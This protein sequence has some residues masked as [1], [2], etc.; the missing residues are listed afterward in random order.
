MSAVNPIRLILVRHAEV[1]ARYQKIFGGKIDMNLS[2]R[3]SE[4]A[5]M[6]ANFL[7]NKPMDA[8][9]A[10]PMKRVQ[11]T[12]AP[13]LKNHGAPSP[14][15]LPDLRE[16]DF[17]D[18][19]GMNWEQVAAKFNLLTHEWLDHIERGVAPNGESGPQFRKRVEP[20]VRK[21]ILENPGKTVGVFC[22]GG[23]IRMILSI[24]LELPLPR[25]NMFEVE[26]ASVTEI[27]LNPKH[28]EIELLNFTPW[29]DLV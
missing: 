22:H 5:Q 23:V 18:W 20:C 10:S 6:L 7:R 25:T 9:Y 2:P 26:Y 3:G 4:Q 28:A 12:L 24:L 19:T 21:I 1:E 13:V 17:G 15:V 11:Q 14:A 27:A 29:R 16:V 8:I